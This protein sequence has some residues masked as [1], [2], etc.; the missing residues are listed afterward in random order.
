[1]RFDVLTLF[2]EIFAGYLTQSLLADALEKK[3]VTVHLHNIRDWGQGRHSAAP[4]PSRGCC[5]GGPLPASSPARR[6]AGSASGS[7]R[8]SPGTGSGRQTSWR[9]NRRS[10]PWEG[11]ATAEP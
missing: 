7:R 6:P 5:A 1:M 11:E 10:R 2:P 4:A 9:F 3:L 8:R